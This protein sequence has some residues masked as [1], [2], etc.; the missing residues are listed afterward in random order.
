MALSD[1]LSVPAGAAASAASGVIGGL[2]SLLGLGM[3]GAAY[4]ADKVGGNTAADYLRKGAEY[5]DVV[6]PSSIKGKIDELTGGFTAAESAPNRVLQD[7]LMEL[8]SL[9]GIPGLS[10]TK[11]AAKVLA[12]GNTLKEGLKSAGIDEGA[13]ELAKVASMFV[14]PA[15]SGILKNAVGKGG[16]LRNVMRRLYS[17]A[18][19][20]VPKGATVGVKNIEGVANDILN[21][22]RSGITS[23]SP[24]KSKLLRIA[25]DVKNFI[26]KG[27]VD[28]NKAVEAYR[29]I[30]DAI[31]S[32]GK[33]SSK[34]ARYLSKLESSL[35]DS[36][37]AYAKQNP[38]WGKNFFQAQTL[39]GISESAPILDKLSKINIGGNKNLNDLIKGLTFLKFMPG[40][41]IGAAS[42][43]PIM[44]YAEGALKSPALRKE[45]MNTITS[46]SQK[47]APAAIKSINRFAK[48]YDARRKQEIDAMRA[49]GFND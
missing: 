30:R 17:N 46:I 10:A 37:T 38:E 14:T 41:A 1:L 2:P 26:G 35:K 4:L 5:T 40:G 24:Q 18:E 36:L 39:Y 43:Q 23:A 15:A 22:A 48:A 3:R 28:V 12:L 45:L 6:S 21:Y 32:I 13:A 20:A 34:A 19:K 27:S 49:F 47:S 33:T 7:T 31:P 9:V 29:D 42:V 16:M 11:G 25:A 8:G 44:R